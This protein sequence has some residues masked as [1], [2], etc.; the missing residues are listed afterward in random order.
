MPYSI[1]PSNVEVEEN[2]GN[3]DGSLVNILRIHGIQGLLLAGV[4]NQ[5]KEVVP[6]SGLVVRPLEAKKVEI[7]EGSEP[8]LETTQWGE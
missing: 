2:P 8:M 7:V 6:T 5:L 1:F 3:C 4:G